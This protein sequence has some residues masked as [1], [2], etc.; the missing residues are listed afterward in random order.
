VIVE[1]NSDNSGT[2]RV[3]PR[4]D[5]LPNLRDMGGISTTD[6]F[7]TREGV[8]YRSEAPIGL[9]GTALQQ[10]ADLGLRT[11]VDLR[12]AAE[13]RLGPS[14]FATDVEKIGIEVSCPADQNGTALLEMVMSGR[15]TSY[16]AADLGE[17]YVNY[18]EHQAE[19]F[20]KV[21]RLI[22]DPARTPLLVHC[23]AGKDR[24]GLTMALV[25]DVIG[26]DRPTILDDYVLTSTFRAHRLTEVGPTLARVGT[27]TSAVASLFAAPP[28]AL[29]MAFHHIDHTYRSV[30]EYLSL[31]AEVSQETLVGLRRQLLDAGQ[32]HSG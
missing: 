29:T 2:P 13:C 21:I 31:R 7:R 25:L 15:L 10:L 14:V 6:G 19:S 4:V 1:R 20:G 9:T 18:L 22:A 5:G 27:R 12:D 17:L 3:M 23:T 28:E 26:V 16:S 24:T 30:E 11:V 32:P 8:L